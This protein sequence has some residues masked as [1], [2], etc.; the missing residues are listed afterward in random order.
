M[1]FLLLD[2]GGFCHIF[3][4]VQIKGTVRPYRFKNARP[5]GGYTVGNT[6]F[7]K[8]SLERSWNEKPPL[9][10]FTRT[11]IRFHS[12]VKAMIWASKSYILSAILIYVKEFCFYALKLKYIVLESTFYI[13]WIRTYSNDCS[14]WNLTHFSKLAFPKA[15][16]YWILK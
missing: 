1:K 9:R 4:R 12:E 10:V 11:L 8:K 7:Y 3:C 15:C 13:D 16:I 6:N 2:L 14:Y 5:W